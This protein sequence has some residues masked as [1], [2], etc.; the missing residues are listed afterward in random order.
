MVQPSAPPAAV[1]IPPEERSVVR[2]AL[3]GFSENWLIPEEDVPES[4]WHDG[5]LELLKALLVAWVEATS[6]HAAV[7]R[8][9]AIQVRREKPKVGWNPDLCL[10]EPAPEGAEMLASMRLWEHAP[11]SFAF[12]AVSPGHPFK[13]YTVVPEKCAL[14]GVTELC[15]FDPLL[16]G[17]CWW[18]A[19]PRPR[20]T[21]PRRV[22][23]TADSSSNGERARPTSRT[24][25]RRAGH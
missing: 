5:C 16:A 11:P 25:F 23:P 8:D 6:R 9:M 7:F 24:S 13:D 20:G 18:H 10:V 2:Y 19:T 21:R 17:P 4:A 3:S 1:R 14:A 22:R 15:V 12:E